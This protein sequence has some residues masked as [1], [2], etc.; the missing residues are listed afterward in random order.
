MAVASTVAAASLTPTLSWGFSIDVSKVAPNLS[1]SSGG[2]TLIYPIYTTGDNG[3]STTSFSLTNTSPAEVV[4]T[5]I[6]FREQLRSMDAMDFDI[7]LSPKDKF[8]FTVSKAPGQRPVMGWDGD[9]SCIV[10]P[11]AGATSYPFPITNATGQNNNSYVYDETALDA[12][13]IEVL[14]MA[15]L[16]PGDNICYD[17]TAGTVKYQE[18]GCNTGEV[19]LATAA[20]HVNGVPPDCADVRAVLI[21]QDLTAQLNA[22]GV[23]DAPN[24]L[25]GRY[26]ITVP[27]KGIEGG[28]D[29]IAIQNSDLPLSAQSVDFCSASTNCVSSY[30]WDPREYDHPHLGDM[31][32]GYLAN[33]EAGMEAANVAGD[34]S[35]NPGNSV[36]VDWVMSFPTKYLYEDVTLPPDLTGA[37]PPEGYPNF[38]MLAETPHVQPKVLP[39]ATATPLADPWPWDLYNTQP[40]ATFCLPTDVVAFGTEEQSGTNQEVVSPSPTATLDFC[41]ELNVLTFDINGQALEP[42]YVATNDS[43]GDSR[44]TVVSFDVNSAKPVVNGWSA[45]GL[46]WSTVGGANPASVEG[47]IYTV[48]DTDQA[49]INN[50]SLTELQKNVGVGD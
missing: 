19:N 44:R 47:I 5:K 21:S 43:N 28:G 17:A 2:D 11:H 15:A 31:P 39:A 12:G 48:R 24:S 3:G 46:T 40:Q 10:G 36:G 14:A 20:T 13:H 38:E 50:G 49:N 37:T 29:A 42:S 16:K 4:I 26:V 23:G 25:V 32:D 41:N 7:V 8:N 9:T 27:G 22:A 1:S 33:F 34:W 30:N 35:N 18:T 6:R 45:L